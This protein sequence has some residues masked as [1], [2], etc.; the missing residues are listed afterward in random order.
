MGKLVFHLILKID[1]GFALTLGS[2]KCADMAQLA[3]LCTLESRVVGKEPGQR[4]LSPV[5]GSMGLC[6]DG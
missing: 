2:S 1:F 4:K 6:F 5:Q 3:Q